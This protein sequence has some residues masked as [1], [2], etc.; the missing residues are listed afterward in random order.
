MQNF[1]TGSKA[2]KRIGTTLFITFAAVLGLSSAVHATEGENRGL[3]G[4]TV[5]GG[6]RGGTV[7]SSQE[8]LLAFV[9]DS[10]VLKTTDSKATLWFYV[11]DSEMLTHAELIVYDEHDNAVV[12]TTFSVEEQAGLFGVNLNL[13]EEGQHISLGKDYRWFFSLICPGNRAADISVDGWVQSTALSS[14]VSSELSVADP[15][16]QAAL[17]V[18][19]G[20]WSEALSLM[21]SEQYGDL[22]AP[23]LEG[24]M[25][26]MQSMSPIPVA[27]DLTTAS[28]L[29]VESPLY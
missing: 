18:Q 7:C 24:W 1:H 29:T 21:L 26:I 6:S 3:P 10:H 22:D 12:D 19:E 23:T 17:Y 2:F 9:P 11:P 8:P 25:S 16:E 13:M 27:L 14:D 4:G 5:G 15:L 28:Q 20:L